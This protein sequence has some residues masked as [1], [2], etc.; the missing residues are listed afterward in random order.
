[1]QNL[2]HQFDLLDNIRDTIAWRQDPPLLGFFFWVQVYGQYTL[3]LKT[4]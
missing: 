1:M 3:K 2:A 4:Q